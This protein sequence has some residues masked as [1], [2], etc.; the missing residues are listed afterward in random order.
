MRAG[1]VV[2]VACAGCSGILDEKGSDTDVDASLQVVAPACDMPAATVPDGHHNP[3][4]DCLMCHHQGGMA[5]PYSYA[6]TLYT[7][8]GGAMPQAGATIHVIDS[9]GNDAIAVT[10]DNGNFWSTDLVSF[11]AIAFASL[12]PDVPPMVTP[13]GA[14]DGNCNTSGCHTAGFRLHVP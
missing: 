13:L 8:S 9:M 6:G 12:C 1:A 7:A 3:G 2:I 14:A 10:A 4:E 11:P 5:P